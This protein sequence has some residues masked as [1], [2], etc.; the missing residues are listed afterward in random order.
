MRGLKISVVFLLAFTV[1]FAVLS[2]SRA[3]GATAEQYYAAGN[4]YYTA[5]N[6][7]RSHPILQ[8]RHQNEPEQRVCLPADWKLLF[9]PREQAICLSLLSKGVRHA[10]Q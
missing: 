6:Y 10:A 2:S 5:K 9:R 4:Q 3:Q 8:R 1:N 7:T